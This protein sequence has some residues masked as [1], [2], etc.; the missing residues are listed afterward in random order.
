MPLNTEI[1]SETVTS[2]SAC[3]HVQIRQ[4]SAFSIPATIELNSQEL[5]AEDIALL[6][7]IEYSIGPCLHKTISAADAWNDADDNFLFPLIQEDTFRIRPG[8]YDF[9]VRLK[10]ISGDVVPWIS[11]DKIHV[12]PAQSR[13]VL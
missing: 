1:T 4:G 3:N 5:G 7:L 8:V 12:L 13:E 6:D 10:F 2:S 9:G 11:T